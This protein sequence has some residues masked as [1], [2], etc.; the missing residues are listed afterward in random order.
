[1]ATT[2]L[3]PRERDALIQSLRSGVMPRLGAWSVQVGHDAEIGALH[4]VLMKNL[5]LRTK[6]GGGAMSTVVKKFIPLTL[7]EARKAEKNPENIIHEKL[8]TLSELVMGDDFASVM[9]ADE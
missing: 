8:Q 5:P 4:A 2:A 9:A 3:R 6:S 1:M 7:A